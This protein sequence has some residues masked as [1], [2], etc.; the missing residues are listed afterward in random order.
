MSTQEQRLA[1]VEEKLNDISAQLQT[2][3]DAQRPFV[4]MTGELGPIASEVLKTSIE[5]CAHLEERGYFAFA[6][7]LKYFVD[8]IVE[9]YDPR[10][11]HDLANNAA[12]I[13]DTARS[14]TQPSVMAMARDV[15]EAFH[16]HRT[17][18]PVGI[19]GAYRT[20][21]KDK[22]VQRGIAFALDLLGRVGRAAARAPRLSRAELREL[23]ESTAPVMK[24]PAAK[25]TTAPP[26]TVSPAATTEALDDE[27]VS[28]EIWCREVGA[29]RAAALGLPQLSDDQWKLVECVRVEWTKGGTTPNIRKITHLSGFST[30]EIYS[31]FPTAPGLTIAKI[32]GVPKPAGCL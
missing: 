27:V 18:K 30:R 7:E 22:N 29:E 5:Q 10:D 24:R 12:N 17:L 3:I 8:R 2:I 9:D 28:S 11:L 31:L 1:A 19:L 20:I 15:A 13:L 21:K 6:H 25:T 14:L 4:E 32:A 23:P 16:E 26:T